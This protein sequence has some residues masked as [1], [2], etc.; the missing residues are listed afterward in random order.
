MYHLDCGL[1]KSL[2]GDMVHIIL[3]VHISNSRRAFLGFIFSFVLI[4][5]N[6]WRK[7]TVSHLHS[8]AKWAYMS[9]YGLDL[10]ARHVI[11]YSTL[12]NPG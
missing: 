5:V 11:I 7:L 3:Q 10:E 1:G 2:E 6:Y 12:H 4:V 9:S 8:I